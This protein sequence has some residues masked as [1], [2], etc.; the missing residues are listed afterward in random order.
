M[1][2]KLR[3]Y[4]FGSRHVGRPALYPWDEWLDGSIVEVTEGEDVPNITNFRST[5]HQ[6]AERNNK[7]VRSR[8]ERRSDGPDRLVFQAKR[9]YRKQVSS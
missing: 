6:A 3:S 8:R 2:R 9:R 5:L 7:S 1:A 4:Q